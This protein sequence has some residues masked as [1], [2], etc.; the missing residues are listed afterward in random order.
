MKRPKGFRYS[1]G[2]LPARNAGAPE[3]EDHEG[4]DE[5][6][7]LDLSDRFPR[8]PAVVSKD[9][10]ESDPSEEESFAVDENENIFFDDEGEAQ[11]TVEILPVKKRRS[12]ALA[13]LWTRNEAD[14]DFTRAKQELKQ[15]ERNRKRRERG[16]RHR[17]TQHQREF[18]TRVFIALGAVTLL[19]LSVAVGVFTPLMAV[20]HIEVRGSDRVPV[21]TITESLHALEGTPLAMVSDADVHQGLRELSL[22]QSFEIEK[23][24]PHTLRV[25][26]I[27]REPVVAVPRGDDLLLIDPSGVQIGTVARDERP[28]GIPVVRGIGTDFTSDRFISMATV[29][30]AMPEESR[31]QIA[32]ISAETPHQISMIMSDG[33][34]VV[35]GDSTN[36]NR[37]ALVLGSMLEAL[38]EVPLRSVDVSSPEAPVYVPA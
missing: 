17:F 7:T 12:K 37:K 35:W 24:P 9:A 19:V 14:A 18:R 2:E 4:E 21:E 23:I 6:Q 11:E 31:G 38:T 1:A 10:N 5:Q 25:V 32:E 26:V 15:A 20:K 34:P 16:E 27:E 3:P 8:L 29:L 22:L 36:N 28:Q 13:E 33:L 30:R